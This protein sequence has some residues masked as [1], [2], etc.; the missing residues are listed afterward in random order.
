MIESKRGRILVVDDQADWCKSLVEYLTRA[1]FLADAVST[2][3]E[4]L[5][6]LEEGLYHLLV[7]DIRLRDGDTSDVKGFDLL[8]ELKQRCLTEAIR[9]I[10][11][12]AHGTREQMRAAF[13]DYEVADFLS[14]DQFSEQTFIENVRN[15]FARYVNINLDLSIIW[16][17][18]S[19]ARQAVCGLEMAGARV[20]DDDILCQRMA[21]E[22]EDLLR[23]LFS[24][25][26]S[27]MVHPLM[28]ALSRSGASVLSVQPFYP[29]GGGHTVV[30]KFGHYK[31]IGEEGRCYRKYVRPFVAGGRST[32]IEN[33]RRTPRQGGIV[34]SLLGAANDQWTDFSRFYCQNSA[35]TICSAIR[36]LF[37]D[38][39]G[40]WYANPGRF[41]PLDLK[42]IYVGQYGSTLEEMEQAAHGL[43]TVLAR[44]GKLYFDSLNVGRYGFVDPFPL[45]KGRDFVYPTYQ[46]FTHGDLNQ[47]NILIDDSAHLWLIDFE[48]AG[49]SHI[50]RDVATLDAI[51]RFQLLAPDEA[52][53]DERL[54]VEQV[55][56]RVKGFRQVE[57]LNTR[58]STPNRMLAKVYETVCELRQVAW[59]LVDQKPNDDM[60]EYYVALL[61]NALNTLQFS[62][63]APIQREHALLSAS[64]L[65]ETLDLNHH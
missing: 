27:I 62:S 31:K 41:F 26:E 54:E 6:R 1:G 13:R 33:T 5:R 19:N 20:G 56:C 44:N 36:C 25:A 18:G 7:L 15:A 8:N 38:T 65:T 28:P 57:H 14:K 23:R 51:V 45:L 58:F 46:C 48:K 53:L 9:I 12:S 39:C 24:E 64:L 3:E 49:L 11:L 50:L 22:L 21:D 61:F 42:E 47:H 40:A 29:A 10:M 30:V 16:Q 32:I 34:Y 59:W 2:A 43:P 37:R 4:A 17:Q 35:A 63:L 52:T 60:S 55:L